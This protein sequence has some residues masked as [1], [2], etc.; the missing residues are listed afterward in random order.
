[1][2]K[3]SFRLTLIQNLPRDSIVR[4]IVWATALKLGPEQVLANFR[5]W[6]PLGVMAIKYA[7]KKADFY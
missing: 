5:K 4:K 2:D 1:V 3:L 7:E 6:N